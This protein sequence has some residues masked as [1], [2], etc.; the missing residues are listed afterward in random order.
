M[1]GG[2][3]IGFSQTTYLSQ[4]DCAQRIYALANFMKSESAFAEGRDIL[5]ACDF[6]LQRTLQ[7]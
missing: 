3:K 4:K 5:E 6:F 1:A 7:C 2:M